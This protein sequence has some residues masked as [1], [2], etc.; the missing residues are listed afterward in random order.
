MQYD[1]VI[2]ALADGK[3]VICD[4]ARR[5]AGLTRLLGRLANAKAM[6]TAR[7]PLSE[8]IEKGFRALL[9][10]RE[11]HVKILVHP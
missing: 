10:D 2:K 5:I 9:K 7:L 1:E 6:I 11:K 8:S 4:V 3:S